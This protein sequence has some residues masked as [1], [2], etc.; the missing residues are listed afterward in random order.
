MTEKYTKERLR[1]KGGLKAIFLAAA[2]LG[3]PTNM[4]N[5]A[6]QVEVNDLAQSL[7][8][9][10]VQAR[11]VLS[12]K[13]KAQQDWASC[14]NAA[15]AQDMPVGAALRQELSSVKSAEIQNLLSYIDEH[16]LSF[17]VVDD[18]RIAQGFDPD[19][20][21]FS[22]MLSTDKRVNAMNMAHLAA[23]HKLG[24]FMR[25]P[26]FKAW[27]Y[28]SQ[29][30]FALA[31]KARAR[32][33]MAVIVKQMAAEKPEYAEI[34]AGYQKEF[35]MIITQGAQSQAEAVQRYV[36]QFLHAPHV[37]KYYAPQLLTGLF[38]DIAA[39]DA[40]SIGRDGRGMIWRDAS[41]GAALDAM[42]LKTK[43]LPDIYA[44]NALLGKYEDQIAYLSNQRSLPVR[45]LYSFHNK[46]A[47][48]DM[49]TLVN[50]YEDAGHVLNISQVFERVRKG[51]KYDDYDLLRDDNKA[52]IQADFMDYQIGPEQVLLWHNIQRINRQQ[53]VIGQLLYK[54]AVD[55]NVFF[56]EEN[57][58]EHAS[59]TWSS[60][61]N[62]V[63]VRPHDHERYNYHYAVGT[64]AHELL[65]A[66]QDHRG[67]LEYSDHWSLSEYQIQVMSYEAAAFVTA[68]LT[69]FELQMNDFDSAPWQ[70]TEKSDV[71]KAIEQTYMRHINADA[72]HMDALEFAGAQA[73]QTVFKD[74][75]W[76]D[77]YNKWAVKLY[78]DKLRHGSLSA[79]RHQEFSLTQA[80][81]DG[82]VSPLFNATARIDKLPTRTALFGDNNTMRHLFNYLEMAFI[83][84][85]WGETSAVYLKYK[86]QLK[87]HD[88]PFLNNLALDQLSLDGRTPHDVYNQILCAAAQPECEKPDV[89]TLPQV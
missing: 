54:H 5:I 2:L 80:R 34:A 48:V 28:K 66:I 77:T 9:N 83:A 1:K 60:K 88:N 21:R 30:V 49:N 44:L 27:D 55:Y 16:N 14:K 40:V 72:T 81:G 8:Q 11:F 20:G 41:G 37:Y 22:L 42:G 75:Y 62:M 51:Y 31:V 86:A 64:V 7:T 70:S 71:A 69:A 4:H 39:G 82:Y 87:G 61:H 19:T 63:S 76:L 67:I 85:K 33:E 24:R 52:A 78:I 50:L 57:A 59:G 32:A 74:Q 15:P 89:K 58:D 46:Y 6:A 13:Y 47:G 18:R 73:W 17:C 84:Q 29:L 56:N 10:T 38:E 45:P 68:R 53:T 23:E 26:A 12:K 25:D 3:A 35:P 36:K 65:H 79:Q 43:D